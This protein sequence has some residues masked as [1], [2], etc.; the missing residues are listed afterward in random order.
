[1]YFFISKIVFFVSLIVLN[2]LF[3]FGKKYSKFCVKNLYKNWLLTDL[4]KERIDVNDGYN[5]S[6]LVFVHFFTSLFISLIISILWVFLIPFIL[7][8]KA[9]NLVNNNK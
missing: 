8:A 4:H 7:I 5:F 9:L 6:I 3:I 2:I 1:M